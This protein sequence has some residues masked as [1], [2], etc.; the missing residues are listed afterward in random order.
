MAT[1]LEKIIMIT[2]TRYGADAQLLLQN[3]QLER[4]YPGLPVA[5]V[6]YQHFLWEMERREMCGNHMMHIMAVMQKAVQLAEY[7]NRNGE[8]IDLEKLMILALLHDY[9]NLDGDD[10][11]AFHALSGYRAMMAFG[12]PV[13]A[14]VCLTHS[15]LSRTFNPENYAYPRE[16][17][18]QVK[19][20][21]GDAP[22]DMYDRIIQISV[23]AVK[24]F[25]PVSMEN[26][27]AA[28]ARKFSLPEKAEQQLLADAR[29]LKAYFD[30]KCGCD[31]YDVWQFRC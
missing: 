24:G 16:D 2:A 7:L 23:F 9:G 18:E 11:Q 12:Y 28:I 5:N 29:A 30:G 22:F 26:H 1:E 25:M 10:K 15:F 20:L 3:M 8:D 14:K 4:G 31:I 13:V 27:A 19:V 17:V 6:L 21:L